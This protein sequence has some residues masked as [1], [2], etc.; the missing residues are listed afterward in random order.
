[1]TTVTETV[2]LIERGRGFPEAAKILGELF[3]GIL[4]CDGWA[5]YRGF[6]KAERQLCLAHL[7]RRCK[8]LLEAPP[9]VGKVRVALLVAASL[10]VPPESASELVAV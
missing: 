10:I 3:A 2:Y 9:T 6:T 4:G 8:E 5:P 1:M 7:L